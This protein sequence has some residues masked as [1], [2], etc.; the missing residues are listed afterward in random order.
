[1]HKLACWKMQYLAPGDTASS[2]Y[3]CVHIPAHVA[4]GAGGACR[5]AAEWHADRVLGLPVRA[6]AASTL[7]NVPL[8][9]WLQWALDPRRDIV[10]A[11]T[12]GS[13]GGSVLLQLGASVL[14]HIWRAHSSTLAHSRPNNCDVPQGLR[15]AAETKPCMAYA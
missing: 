8:G 6:R 5:E 10:D 2:G 12:V 14:V 7:P 13:S 1:M 4:G 11:L 15:F 9:A 3:P